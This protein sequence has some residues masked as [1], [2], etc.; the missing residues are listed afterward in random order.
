MPGLTDAQLA[1]L[2]DKFNQLVQTTLVAPV[3]K[4]IPAALA[5]FEQIDPAQATLLWLQGAGGIGPQG[6]AGPAGP[7]GATG[8][9]GPAGPTGATGPVGPTG[10]QGPIGVPGATGATGATGPMGPIGPQGPAGAGI[11]IMGTVANSAALP[12]T[13]APGQAWITA[14]TGHL[15][16]WSTST[17]TWT[18]V[19]PFVGPPGPAGPGVPAGGTTGQV[20]EKTSGTDYATAWTTPSWPASSLTGL[21]PKQILFGSPTGTIE[22]LSY[23]W[24]E[25]QGTTDFG[26]F[27]VGIPVDPTIRLTQWRG[28]SVNAGPFA[29]GPPERTDLISLFINM[30][31]NPGVAGQDIF[32]FSYT[33]V[34]GSQTMIFGVDADGLD[35]NFNFIHWLADPVAVQDGANKRYVDARSLPVG[36]TAGQILA[37]NTAT[38]YDTHWIAAPTGGGGTTKNLPDTPQ[39]FTMTLA[40]LG[41]AGYW[42]SAAINEGAQ[43]HLDVLV[44]FAIRLAA[45]GI[46]A[47]GQIGVYAYASVDG[48]VTYTEGLPGTN[49]NVGGLIQNPTN[50]KFLGW[51]TANV[52]GATV[53]GGPYSIALAFGRVPQYWGIVIQNQT[54]AAFDATEANHKKEYQGFFEIAA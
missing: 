35:M 26:S 32:D 9:T 53:V 50:L 47:T 16:V 28:I 30:T 49:S 34:G 20:L 23:L 3:T 14:D 46:A 33:P 7:A 51:I 17:S 40:S 29:G 10:T 38:N 13:G 2:V 37:K 54:G 25:Q 1:T 12:A 44:S 41:N 36:G 4:L 22:Q 52:N 39:T 6:P 43:G 31:V 42:S 27:A 19:G 24:F 5:D 18:D 48:G 21:A 15:W 11:A 8:A 45:S